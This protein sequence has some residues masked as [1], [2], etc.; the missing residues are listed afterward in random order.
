MQKKLS[1]MAGIPPSERIRFSSKR[2]SANS[3]EVSSSEI[4]YLVR[5]IESE[6]RKQ[7]YNISLLDGVISFLKCQ[8]THQFEGRAGIYVKKSFAKTE[9]QTALSFDNDD[10]KVKYLIYRYKFAEFPQKKI[11]DEFPIVIAIEPTSWCNIHCAMCFQAD[12]NFFT[13]KKEMGFIDFG[14]YCRLI[15]E[16][17]DNQPCSLV[18][19]SRGEPLLHKKFTEMV[20]YATKKEIIDVKINTNAT[21]L[22]ESKVRELLSAEPTT[23]VFSVDAGNKKEFE[24]I[25]QGANFDTVVKNIR[26]FNEIRKKEFSH[27]KTRT[28]ISMTVFRKSQDSKEAENLWANMVDEF[29]IHSADYRLDVYDHPPLPNET[30]PCNILW[31]RLYVWWNGIVNPCDTDYKSCLSLGT[32]KDGG[33]IKSMWLG[34]KMQKLRAD[35]LAGKKNHFYPCGQCYGF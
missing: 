26:M 16:V 19:A 13:N 10:L 15:D 27:S 20:A 7:V 8:T 24:E 25:R 5:L 2:Y 33:S 12:R 6:K 35:N 14:F 30:R 11:V 23:I 21:I 22:T 9:L 31:E 17:A 1:E 29:A 28:R 32:I 3:I 4:D 34:E 18:L